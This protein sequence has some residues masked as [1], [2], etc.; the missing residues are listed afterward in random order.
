MIK[1]QIAPAPWK[2]V[3][4]VGKEQMFGQCLR[5]LDGLEIFEFQGDFSSEI[6]LTCC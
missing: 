2:K 5:T 6:M 3:E 4:Q 1:T